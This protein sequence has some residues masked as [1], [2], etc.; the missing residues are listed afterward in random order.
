MVDDASVHSE[1]SYHTGDSEGHLTVALSNVQGD[2]APEPS[3]TV[4]QAKAPARK[5]VVVTPKETAISA[6]TTQVHPVALT[7]LPKQVRISSVTQSTVATKDIPKEPQEV[8][9]PATPAPISTPA[10]TVPKCQFPTLPGT[11][12]SYVTTSP[13]QYPDITQTIFTPTPLVPP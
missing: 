7:V 3:N 6:V 4:P 11:P 10:I 2:T 9:V 5:E 12:T 1:F 8:V 13:V